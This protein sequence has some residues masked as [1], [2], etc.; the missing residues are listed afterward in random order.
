MSLHELKTNKH[1]DL[2]ENIQPIAGSINIGYHA[3]KKLQS[4]ITE[5]NVFLII[6]LDGPDDV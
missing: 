3:E 6:H 4:I 1:M 2:Q 5:H